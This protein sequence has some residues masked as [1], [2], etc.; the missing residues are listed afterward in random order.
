MYPVDDK[1]LRGKTLKLYKEKIKT[2]KKKKKTVNYSI[3]GSS[4]A[5]KVTLPWNS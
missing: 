4:K 1:N 3:L 2:P 5:L